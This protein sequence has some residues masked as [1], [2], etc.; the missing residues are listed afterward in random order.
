[1]ERQANA[2]I[3]LQNIKI[4]HIICLLEPLQLNV[5]FLRL[6]AAHKMELQPKLTA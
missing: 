5:F 2:L 4:E 6:N 1:M 3:K